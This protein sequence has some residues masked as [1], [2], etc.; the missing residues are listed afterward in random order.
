M[1][2][3]EVKARIKD[4]VNAIIK[5]Q[6]DDATTALHDVLSAKM[7]ARVGN[8]AETTAE[9]DPPADDDVTGE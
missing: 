3:E 1:N 6:P 2:P 7:R 4:A 5:D 9:I 8:D